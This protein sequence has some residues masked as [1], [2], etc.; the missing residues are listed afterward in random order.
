MRS[1]RSGPLD[2]RQWSAIDA[3]MH[4]DDQARSV[5]RAT[6]HAPRDTTP[7]DHPAD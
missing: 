2:R 6:L 4:D 3:R 7:A 1:R 5:T